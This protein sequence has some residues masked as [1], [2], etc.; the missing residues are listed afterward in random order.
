MFSEIKT[1]RGG[2]LLI[3]QLDGAEEAQIGLVDST[4]TKSV[5]VVLTKENIQELIK[6]IGKLNV[7]E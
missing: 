1:K 3:Y 4:D 5:D 2:K 6:A 7:R